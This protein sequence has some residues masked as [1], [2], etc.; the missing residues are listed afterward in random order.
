[1]KSV[2]T[3]ASALT[4]VLTASSAAAQGPPAAPLRLTLDEAV[5]R[6]LETSHRIA[7]AGA[8]GFV[9]KPI[10][11]AELSTAIAEALK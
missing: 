1:M 2:L 4:V 8:R 10:Q 7:Q 11:E 9:A 3:L 5:Q 6:G